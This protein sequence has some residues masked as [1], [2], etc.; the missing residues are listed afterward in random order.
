MRDNG[1]PIT[2]AIP[3][4]PRVAARPKHAMYTHAIE[5]DAGTLPIAAAVIAPL[6]ASP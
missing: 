6:P 2:P 5:G 1:K 4:I 3:A